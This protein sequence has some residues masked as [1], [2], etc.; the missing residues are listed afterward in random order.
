VGLAVGCAVAALLTTVPPAGADTHL[1]HPGEVITAI[2]SDTTENFMDLILTGPDEYNVRAQQNPT[3][4]VPGD[5]HCVGSA[6]YNDTPGPG[7]FDAPQGSGAGRIAFKGAL[8]GTWPDTAHNT[9][10]S[11][12]LGCADIARSSSNPGLTGPDPD[13][14]NF[15]FYGFGM[16]AITWGSPSFSAPASMTITDLRNIYN[17]SITRWENIPGNRAGTGHIQRFIPQTSSGTW[18][19]FRDKVLG[20]DAST[21]TGPDCPAVIQNEENHGTELVSPA[22]RSKYQE[23]II[24]YDAGKWV[25]QANSSTNLTLD[26]RGGVRPGGLDQGT[27]PSPVTAVRWTGTAFKLNDASI[28]NGRTVNDAVT[29]GTFGTPTFVVTSVA[30]AFTAADVGSTVAGTNIPAGATII[31]VSG[32]DATISLPITSSA[33]GGSLTIGIAV[34]S[35]KNPNVFV[36]GDSSIWPGVRILWNVV[37]S[38]SPS[39]DTALRIVGFV[40]APGGDKSPLCSGTDASL[41]SSQGFLPLPPRTSAN[42]NTGVTCYSA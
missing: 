1:A 18:A 32:N 31:S 22:N 23:A 4:T 10:A 5:A 15:E 6:S 13:P 17:C 19:T 28:V 33:V 29:T 38:D 20:F 12:G 21:I 41:I 9:P 26:I 27:T 11:A 24:G 7:V 39:Y 8:A 36:N 34:I 35:E 2:G 3:L 37:D 14:V 16:S 40:D 42:G 30:A 25:T